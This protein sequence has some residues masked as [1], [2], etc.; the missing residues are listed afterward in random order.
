M[1]TDVEV[2][3]YARCDVGDFRQLERVFERCGPFDYVYHCAA[4]FGRWN[5]EDLTI[6]FAG[7]TTLPN[8]TYFVKIVASDERSNA[9]DSALRGEAVSTAFDI[10]N[11]PPEITMS[12]VRRD[13]ARLML[14][15]EVRDEYSAVQR[16]DYSLDGEITGSCAPAAPAG[17]PSTGAQPAADTLAVGVIVTT[18]RPP[19]TCANASAWCV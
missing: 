7:T 19:R 2:P 3:L 5:G 14:D 12:S 4:E 11:T 13:G 8:G 6:A 18:L 17:A 15:F 9:P 16:A 10:D 1:S